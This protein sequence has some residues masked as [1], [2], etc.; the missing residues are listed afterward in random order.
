MCKNLTY[1]DDLVDPAGV[2]NCNLW[3]EAR[4]DSTSSFNRSFQERTEVIPE[5][6]TTPA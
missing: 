5:P 2:N 4:D 6:P 1:S 3:S